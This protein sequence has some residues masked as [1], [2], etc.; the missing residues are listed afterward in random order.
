MDLFSS[1]SIAAQFEPYAI[2]I[3]FDPDSDGNLV[4]LTHEQALAMSRQ[5]VVCV[6]T[7]TRATAT[8]RTRARTEIRKATTTET[9]RTRTRRIK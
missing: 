7:T 3:A 8:T 4:Q 1:N 6:T 9:K 5:Q 2:I